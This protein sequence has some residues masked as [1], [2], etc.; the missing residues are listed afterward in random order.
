[1]NRADS[2]SGYQPAQQQ[3]PARDKVTKRVK[4]QCKSVGRLY[5]WWMRCRGRAYP[6]MGQQ[7]SPPMPHL[8]LLSHTLPQ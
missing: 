5:I 4:L 3:L 1:M 8:V 6:A 2:C 7:M